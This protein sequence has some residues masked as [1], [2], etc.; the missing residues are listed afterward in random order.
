M[1]GERSDPILILCRA[2]GFGW[3]TA[4]ALM[5]ARPGGRGTSTQALDTAYG[6]FERLSAATA[7]RV[8]RFWQLRPGA[9]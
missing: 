7:Q 6:H 8:L 4:R 9:V 3:P 1:S 2:R 5:L